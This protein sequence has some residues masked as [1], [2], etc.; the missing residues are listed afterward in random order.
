MGKL[1]NNTATKDRQENRQSLTL[2][3]LE[4]YFVKL[5]IKS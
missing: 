1:K 3:A 5:K 2:T 4:K